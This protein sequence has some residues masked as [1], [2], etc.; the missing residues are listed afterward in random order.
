[1]AVN[2]LTFTADGIATV[3]STNSGAHPNG[4]RRDTGLAAAM[5]A[6][7]SAD[8]VHDAVRAHNDSY[9]TLWRAPAQGA[10]SVEAD[11]G[12]ELATRG[13]DIRPEHPWKSYRFELEA[14][15]D[16]RMWRTISAARSYQGSP[17]SIPEPVE[18]RYLRLATREPVRMNDRR[19]LGTV[20]TI[21]IHLLRRSGRHID[22]PGVG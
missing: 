2:R 19:P 20:R 4:A 5:S 10:P 15:G 14:S 8:R 7:G 11:L 18:T 12:S 6:P 3:V 21:W 1:M 13:L 9:A 17:I 22:I 16:G